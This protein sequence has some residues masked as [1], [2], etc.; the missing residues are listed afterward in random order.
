MKKTIIFVSFLYLSLYIFNHYIHAQEWLKA[1][2]NQV[3]FDA[4]C[5]EYR[6]PD[7]FEEISIIKEFFNHKR[8]LNA[9][10]GY[11]TE[12]IL[13]S[14]DGHFIVFTEIGEIF[15]PDDAKKYA[16]GRFVMTVDGVHISAV[17]RILRYIKGEDASDSWKKHIQYY[18]AE[19]AKH[20]FNADTAIIFSFILSDSDAYQDVYNYCKVL[21]MQKKGRGYLPLYCMYDGKAVKNIDTYMTAIESAF[22]YRDCDK[23]PYYQ[24]DR[25]IIKDTDSIIMFIM[26]R[27]PPEVNINNNIPSDACVLFDGS[28]MSQWESVDGGEVGWTVENGI[29]KSNAQMNNIQTIQKFGDCQLHLEWKTDKELLGNSHIFFQKQYEVEMHAIYTPFNRSGSLYNQSAMFNAFDRECEWQVFDIVFIAPRFDTNGKL[30]KQA[31]I[32]VF[33]NGAIVQYDVPV[34]PPTDI[35]QYKAHLELPLELESGGEYEFK[36][37]WIREFKIKPVKKDDQW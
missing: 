24:P 36:N 11:N 26:S 1:Y 19:D 10:L 23:P 13:R 21:I 5:L 32:T 25:K 34:K 35:K 20:K 7:G 30:D 17:R 28:S 16:G 15:S 9:I 31:R 6:C 4:M 2:D 14:N 18:S 29:L 12:G 27:L 37:I 22:R 33:L 3:Q 8:L